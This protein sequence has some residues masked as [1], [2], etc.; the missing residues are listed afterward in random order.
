[1]TQVNRGRLFTLVLDYLFFAGVLWVLYAWMAGDAL[2][3][4]KAGIFV[5]VFVGPVLLVREWLYFAVLGSELAPAKV[6]EPRLT[7]RNAYEYLHV[8]FP[9]TVALPVLVHF[10]WLHFRI[11]DSALQTVGVVNAQYL[12]MG[13]L[14]DV[15]LSWAHPLLHR[16][17]HYYLHKLHHRATKQLTQFNGYAFDYVD[18][19]IENLGAIVLGIGVNKLVTG[20]AELHLGA[21]IL[22]VWNDAI[23]HSANPWSICNP[24]L[25]G[26]DLFLMANI[27][28]NMH[29]A[30]QND[31]YT[32]YPWR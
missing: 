21:F 16:P 12:V 20:M 13:V 9:F 26:L 19:V 24:S 31:Y 22:L 3:P 5:F 6:Q 14:K 17:E 7:W 1:M 29:H 27:C 10:G 25:P 4:W 2:A 30:I 8:I 11:D 18:I 28:H 23:L 32:F 15:V